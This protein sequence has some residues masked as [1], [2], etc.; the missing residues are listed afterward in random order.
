MSAAAATASIRISRG[1]AWWR[2]TRRAAS[3][4]ARSD[5]CPTAG[6]PRTCTSS[7][8]TPAR[9]R[10]PRRS[11]RRAS[12]RNGS[13]D[14][15][16]RAARHARSSSSCWPGVAKQIR[17]NRPTTSC[18]ARRSW[19]IASLS[20]RCKRGGAALRHPGT[21]RTPFACRDLVQRHLREE[22][23]QSAVLEPEHALAQRLGFADLGERE[24]QLVLATPGFE[25]DV[26]LHRVLV[27]HA[28]VLGLEH[29]AL[30]QHEIGTVERVRHG[31]DRG[32]VGSRLRSICRID[33]V[34]GKLVQAPYL[35]PPWLREGSRPGTPP[36]SAFRAPGS[37]ADAR[38][39]ASAEWR[40]P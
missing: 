22:A 21:R 25:D 39:I 11:T 29:H 8:R 23:Q 33:A 5:P 2:P 40:A 14:S 20:S 26:V 1:T 19:T 4:F 37:V 15:A 13:R 27:G 38:A 36:R 28:Q 16:C 34:A 35:G 6:G 32:H 31:I 7:S 17:S 3:R 24:R 9:A 30:E 18:Y 12:L 10:S